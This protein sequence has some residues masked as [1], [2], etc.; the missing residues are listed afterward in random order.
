[1]NLPYRT[2]RKDDD[3]RIVKHEI[4]YQGYFRIERLCLS[5]RLFSGA[6]GKPV[7]REVFERGRAVAVLPYDPQRRQV[8][9]IEQF[10][11]GALTDPRSPWLMEIVAGIIEEGEIEQDVIHREAQE[12]AGIILTDLIPITRY[13]VSPGGCTEYV[14][15]FCGKVDAS[16]ASGFHG[17]PEE[18]EDIK[19]HVVD[20]LDAFQM[21]HDGFINNAATI[22]ALQWLELNYTA[23]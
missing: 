21:V 15:V 8:V 2:Y 16:K 1:M 9:L 14:A 10:R 6:F 4:A 18:N 23:L 7:I 5:Y 12:E 17:L 19:V 20:I 13:W 3:V 11:T 22:I